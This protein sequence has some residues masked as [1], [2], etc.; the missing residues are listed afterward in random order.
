MEK[1][2][3]TRREELIEKYVETVVEHMDLGELMLYAQEMMAMGMDGLADKELLEEVTSLYDYGDD[4]LQD[5]Y[6]FTKEEN[7]I[8][9]EINEQRVD[10]MFDVIRENGG[11]P[12]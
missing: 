5:L 6:K 10:K 7:A 12:L 1:M 4:E 9:D 8:V 2:T 3:R 11:T